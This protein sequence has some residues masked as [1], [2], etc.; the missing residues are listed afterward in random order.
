MASLGWIKVHRELLDSA[1]WQDPHTGFVWVTLLLKANFAD[2]QLLDGRIIKRGQLII[3]Q[4]KL[5]KELLLGRQTIRTSLLRLEKCGNVI[6]ESTNKGTLI[7]ICNYGKYQD[8]N[9]QLTSQSETNQQDTPINTCNESTYAN[10]SAE[11]NRQLT[12][13]QPATGQQLTSSQPQNKKGRAK[14]RKEKNTNEAFRNLDSQIEEVVAHYRTHHPRSRP[15]ESEQIKIAARLNDGYSVAD[16]C[17]AIDGNHVDPYCCGENDSGRTY[18]NLELIVRN[19]GKVDQYMR[20]WDQR[21]DRVLS[22]STKRGMRAAMNQATNPIDYFGGGNGGPNI[23]GPA[24]D[25]AVKGLSKPGSGRAE[26][27]RVSD[28]AQRLRPPADSGSNPAAHP[29]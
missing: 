13:N 26:S 9:Q 19:S 11:A 4:D 27:Q 21:N 2:R 14:R 12:N 20:A 18:H 16:L 24:G 23:F 28:G 6:T 25:D 22:A 29:E 15:G 17:Q 5:A 3:R 10:S 7:T 8:T 1:A